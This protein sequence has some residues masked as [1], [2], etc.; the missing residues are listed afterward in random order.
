MTGRVEVDPIPCVCCGADAFVPQ[1]RVGR[2]HL[3]RCRRCALIRLARMPTPQALAEIYATEHYF[4]N[5][6]FLEGTPETLFGYQDAAAEAELKVRLYARRLR[7]VLREAFPSPAGRTWLDVGSGLGST[8]KFARGEGFDA[9]GIEP[10]PAALARAREAHGDHF[11]SGWIEE[12]RVDRTFDVISLMDVIEHLLDPAACLAWVRDHLTPAGIAL[13]VT[14]DCRSLTSRLLGARLEDFRRVREHV[15]F[16]GRTNFRL[17]A[18]RCG[19][20]TVAIRSWGGYFDGRRL[21]ERILAM[22]GMPARAAERLAAVVPPGLSAY[23][24]PRVKMI[25][26]LRA[27]R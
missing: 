6:D 22:A 4:H 20:R 25:V 3:V 17:L 14:M 15:Y 7:P 19:L 13:V 11:L 26:V 1:Y 27:G 9:I 2:H 8:V 16:F 18:G 5:P 12:V 21:A 23:V 24:D 10:N